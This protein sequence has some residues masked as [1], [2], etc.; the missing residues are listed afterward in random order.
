VIA[1]EKKKDSTQ[2]NFMRML[3]D[4]IG[5]LLETRDALKTAPMN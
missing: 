5:G 3:R 4:I 1:G 2:Y